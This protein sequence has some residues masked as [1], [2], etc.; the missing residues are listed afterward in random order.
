MGLVPNSSALAQAYR[1]TAADNKTLYQ[2]VGTKPG[3]ATSR[4]QQGKLGYTTIAIFGQ[5]F[6]FL[7]NMTYRLPSPRLFIAID[8]SNSVRKVIGTIV[9]Q[10]AASSP[11]TLH[12]VPVNNIHLTIKFLGKTP[13]IKIKEIEHTLNEVCSKFYPFK[14]EVGGLGAFPKLDHPRVIWAGVKICPD[15]A[16]LHMGIEKSMLTLGFAVEN[17]P[18]SAHLTL[19]RVPAHFLPDQLAAISQILKA[20]K[21]NEIGAINVN[22]V[23]LFRSDLMSGGA[24]YTRLHSANLIP[25]S[26]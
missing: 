8:I 17:R 18:F 11:P 21:V 22:S 23:N 5:Q 20:T 7:V 2:S 25:P 9:T 19:S 3:V 1:V 4:T 10:L 26:G 13:S 14:V 6:L 15:L 16:N 24:I 12:W